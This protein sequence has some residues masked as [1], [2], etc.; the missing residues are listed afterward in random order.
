MA[1]L[2]EIQLCEFDVLKEI[3]RICD[4]Y[5]I[6]YFLAYGTMLGAV[7]HKGFI[8]WDDDIDINMTMK[9]FR[10]FKKAFK[11]EKSEDFFLEQSGSIYS[12]TFLYHK[13]RKNGT[14]MP[15]SGEKPDK[16]HNYG[17]WV[18]IFPLCPLA[19]FIPIQNIQ[20]RLIQFIQFLIRHRLGIS[21]RDNSLKL[22]L[23]RVINVML[24]A[25]EKLI[26]CIIYPLGFGGKYYIEL[27]LRFMGNINLDYPRKSI[28]SKKIFEKN[29]DYSFESVMFK[30]VEKYDEY[31]SKCYG[32]DYMTPKKYNQHIANYDDVIV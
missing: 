11:K 8:P 27:D 21:E 16:F 22:L 5:N 6:E 20:I 31:L 29:A 17:V 24:V 32:S 18:D 14:F 3:K 25:I 15:E 12:S 23:K 7:R 19:S 9:E 2:R 30:G 10:K 26:W 4:K 1:N 13:M 28:F